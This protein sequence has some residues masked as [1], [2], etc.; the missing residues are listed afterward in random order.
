MYGSCNDIDECRRNIHTCY[1][2]GSYCQDTHGSYECRCHNGY[3]M[4]ENGTCEDINECEED[5][6]CDVNAQCIN[7][8]GRG[9]SCMCNNGYSGH[10]SGSD[11]HVIVGNL[12]VTSYERGSVNVVWDFAEYYDDYGYYVIWDNSLVLSYEAFPDINETIILPDENKG[13][14]MI[15]NMLPGRTYLIS[16][17]AVNDYAHNTKNTLL[18]FN[19]TDLCDGRPCNFTQQCTSNA[20]TERDITGSELFQQWF[21]C[22]CPDGRVGPVCNLELRISAEVVNTTTSS[23]TITWNLNDESY[24]SHFDQYLIIDISNGKSER[25]RMHVAYTYVVKSLYDLKAGG[26]YS[27]TV[28][29][30]GNM[31]AYNTS[32]HLAVLLDPEPPISASAIYDG[33]SSAIVYW[34]P[35]FTEY[36]AFQVRQ[37]CE[38]SHSQ[39]V[40]NATMV[41]NLPPNSTCRVDIE[42]ILGKRRS[43]ET[44]RYTIETGPDYCESGPCGRGATCVNA[45]GD[46]KCLCPSGISGVLCEVVADSCHDS[47]CA[48]GATCVAGIDRYQCVC[49]SDKI[50]ERCETAVKAVKLSAEMAD[51]IFTDDLT[52]KTSARYKQLESEIIHQITSLFVNTS[53]FQKLEVIEFKPGSIVVV[54]NIVLLAKSTTNEEETAIQDLKDNLDTNGLLNYTIGRIERQE[55]HC[56]GVQ[57]LNSGVCVSEATDYVCYCRDNFIGRNCETEFKEKILLKNGYKMIHVTEEEDVRNPV[58]DV[59]SLMTNPNAAQRYDLIPNAANSTFLLDNVSGKV[60]ATIDKFDYEGKDRYELEIDIFDSEGAA[61]RI[62]LIIVVDNINDNH[63]YFTNT[64]YESTIMEYAPF[65]SLVAAV[66]AADADGKDALTYFLPPANSDI[67]SLFSITED[68][69]ILVDGILNRKRLNND[70]Y[71]EDGKLLI[72]VSVTDGKWTESSTVFLTVEPLFVRD[73]EKNET[74][75]QVAIPENATVG[76]FVADVSVSDPENNE[77][78]YKYRISVGRPDE[79]QFAINE[80]TG[81]IT[82]RLPLDREEDPL[83]RF[84]IIVLENQ[85]LSGIEILLGIIVEDVNDEIPTFG[86]LSYSASIREDA[87]SPSD[88]TPVIIIPPIQATDDDFGLNA[89]IRYSLT[90][91]GMEIFV[92]NPKSGDVWLKANPDLDYESIKEYSLTVVARDRDGNP[93]GNSNSVPFTVKITDA[94]DNSPVFSQQSWTLSIRENSSLP[95]VLTSVHA[96]DADEGLNSELRYH[97]EEGGDGKFRI[98]S[99]TGELSLRSELDRETK[100]E[101][102][103][104]I[105]ARDQGF[106]AQETS[107]YVNVTVLDVNDNSPRFDKQFY[108]GHTPEGQTGSAILTVIA[109]DPDLGENAEIE[110]DLTDGSTFT[111]DSNGTI[112]ASTA[113]DRE[114]VP[115]YDIVVTA[116]DRGM[117]QKSSS[118]QVR[119]VVDDINDNEPQFSSRRYDAKILLSSDGIITAGTLVLFVSATDLDI[120]SNADIRYS[121]TNENYTSIFEINHNGAVRV[122]KNYRPVSSVVNEML[123]FNI[124]AKDGGSPQKE[125]IA[126]VVITFEKPSEVFE[127]NETMYF[128]NVM[129]NEKNV[130]IGNVEAFSRNV[131]KDFVYD[132][133]YSIDGVALNQYTGSINVTQPIDRET[134]SKVTFNVLAHGDYE[135]A[136]GDGFAFTTVEITIQDVNDEVPYFIFP[137]EPLVWTELPENS[138]NDSFVQFQAEDRDQDGPNSQIE[139]SIAYGNGDGV[140][141]IDRSTGVLRVIEKADRESVESYR[142]II[143]ASDQGMPP[144]NT[145]VFLQV[146]ILDENDNT[147]NITTGASTVV[148][149]ENIGIGSEVTFVRASDDDEGENAEIYFQLEEDSNGTFYVSEISGSIRTA[150]LLD[151]ETE[152]AHTIKV[153]AIDK[154]SPAK[155]STP[156]I[157]SFNIEDYNDNAPEF[158]NPNYYVPLPKDS[159]PQT[160]VLMVSAVDRDIG[161]NAMVTYD[162]IG[163][164]NC[165]QNHFQINS[166]TG[167]IITTDNLYDQP[168]GSCLLPVRCQDMGIDP[169]SSISMIEINIEEVNFPP[170]FTSESY[171]A[172]IDENV[173]IG[174]NVKTEPQNPPQATDDDK[175]ANG[176]VYYD[177]VGGNDDGLFSVDRQS[178]QITVSKAL[179]REAIASVALIISAHD[180][181]PDPKSATVVVTITI[182]DANDNAPELPQELNATITQDGSSGALVTTIKARDLDIGKNAECFYHIARA[183]FEGIGPVNPSDYFSINQTDGAITTTDNLYKLNLTST[184]DIGLILVVR[185]VEPLDVG[186]YTRTNL[187]PT[188]SWLTVTFRYDYTPRC[189]EDEYLVNVNEDKQPGES[190]NITIEPRNNGTKPLP[191]LFYEIIWASAW[192]VFSINAVTG[193][194][195]TSKVLDVGTYNLTIAVRTSDP[196]NGEGSCTVLVDVYRVTTIY[197]MTTAAVTVAPQNEDC[198]V[199]LVGVSAVAIVL[200]IILVTV[201]LILYWRTRTRG[202]FNNKQAKETQKQAVSSLDRR[203]FP[204]ERAR[205]QRPNWLMMR[206]LP[207]EPPEKLETFKPDPPED[208][209]MNKYTKM[210]KHFR[211]SQYK[212]GEVAQRESGFYMAVRESGAV[213]DDY[214]H[215]VSIQDAV[216]QLPPADYDDQLSEVDYD[217]DNNQQRIPSYLLPESWQ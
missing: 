6:P 101:Y 49:P 155:T 24:W 88:L 9:Y 187:N 27:I 189:R 91:F 115:A 15:E 186:P 129:E 210:W 12:T 196:D 116:T 133:P 33:G 205:P 130:Y 112:S 67:A 164:G 176:E 125:D 97:M 58:F 152:D 161:I 195:L 141:D 69:R 8:N 179:D 18:S 14:H 121:V 52:D 96:T 151:R 62:L 124:S 79:F 83:Y 145:T 150:K 172:T 39:T 90:G 78:T 197:H 28:T 11:C 135:N 103:L 55:D 201:G 57:C 34:D 85:C 183:R 157:I 147:P 193:D 76:S 22:D 38:L 13:T 137:Q 170:K 71:L 7:Y 87:G 158:V 123:T 80:T 175:D 122:K 167:Q 50:G 131:N 188:A 138:L 114:A 178:G 168:S 82:T 119:I 198:L 84:S 63:P 81:V 190:L 3:R 159:L 109:S 35:G 94:N 26:E 146:E 102:F 206:S 117:P 156:L 60:N 47:P 42:T 166:T 93:D 208:K 59:S 75:Y 4:A 43:A 171:R 148:V 30:V 56:E 140:F 41:I 182:E 142:V 120:G 106:P 139:Y 46:F 10:G 149:N 181:T 2:Q 118:V 213:N 173:W 154:G 126:M 70:G 110:Y 66:T 99:T 21:V 44:Y 215:P 214:I 203:G 128:F 204:S 185:N 1:S 209:S 72:P 25:Q 100:D 17:T 113:L 73:S 163:G 98:D 51:A 216:P 184:I 36:D 23:V 202:K 31:Y 19:F 86:E 134:T 200:F 165:S 111:I 211:A 105:I 143:M 61:T 174:T 68:G 5:N 177:I 77:I 180:V 217:D 207:D 45:N 32:D 37:T 162:I 169:L 89:D 29:A 160:K 74:G 153:V 192:N 107:V 199:I 127:F 191:S 136:E 95:T 92:I 194:I 64:P 144:L 16:L 108:S 212:P 132:L 54:L 65:G 40:K 48:D 20:I 53:T 104:V